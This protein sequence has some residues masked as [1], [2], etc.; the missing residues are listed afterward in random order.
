MGPYP[1]HIIRSQVVDQEEVS[2]CAWGYCACCAA[3]CGIKYN[4]C[5][6]LIQSQTLSPLLLKS[7]YYPLLQDSHFR[8]YRLPN[9]SQNM[10]VF[11][12]FFIISIV[13]NVVVYTKLKKNNNNKNE[14]ECH[15]PVVS[16]LASYL[17]GYSLKSWPR[18]QLS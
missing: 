13:L 7:K 5:E 10:D 8:V 16:T 1:I 15:I 11:F 18:D 12:N 2:S 3:W 9:R 17:G 4:L 14:T 6:L